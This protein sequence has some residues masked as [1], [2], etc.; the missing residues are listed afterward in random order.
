MW[1]ALLCILQSAC[2]RIQYKSISKEKTY[3]TLA[4]SIIPLDKFYLPS[5][6]KT[7][8]IAE[9]GAGQHGVATA[10]VCADGV[11]VYRLYGRS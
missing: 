1:D 8:I 7:R 10:T 9:T 3:A 6:G 4:H 11:A 2:L 5:L